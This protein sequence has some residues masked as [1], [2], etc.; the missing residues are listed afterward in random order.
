MK[1]LESQLKR[2]DK[3]WR[4]SAASSVI[5]RDSASPSHPAAVMEGSS[6][7]GAPLREEL[8]GDLNRVEAG[9]QPKQDL[10]KPKSKGVQEKQGAKTDVLKMANQFQSQ[11][12][13]PGQTREVGEE[14]K[15]RPSSGKLADRLKMFG[16]GAAF[17]KPLP[18]KEERDR[19]LSRVEGRRN[20]FCSGLQH[21]PDVHCP[22][23]PGRA[24]LVL[25][26]VAPAASASPHSRQ[27]RKNLHR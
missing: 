20:G 10:K 25:A 13:P 18:A 6:V 24:R 9:L 17:V 27:S 3:E 16:G 19:A 12:A 21:L 22:R 7:A 1:E 5:S 8:E 11:P 4:G 15:A 23:D 26:D 2:V 14:K